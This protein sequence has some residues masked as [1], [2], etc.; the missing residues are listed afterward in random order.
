MSLQVLE[1]ASKPGALNVRYDP[2]RRGTYARGFLIST[3]NAGGTM[4]DYKINRET[5][6]QEVK[7]FKGRHFIIQPELLKAQK[8]SHFYDSGLANLLK[9][10]E[11]N[12]HGV[13]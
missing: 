9:G 2:E 6:H 5:G 1:P 13:I 8:D 10:Y 3:K 11:A 7:S 4:G 12:S